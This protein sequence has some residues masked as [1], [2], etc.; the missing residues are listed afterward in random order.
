MTVSRKKVEVYLCGFCCLCGSDFAVKG[1]DAASFS[2]FFSYE[3]QFPNI[4]NPSND[5]L[6]SQQIVNKPPNP[7]KIGLK[8]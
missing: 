4:R 6:A 3:L 2:S 1:L 7:P 5:V 8:I